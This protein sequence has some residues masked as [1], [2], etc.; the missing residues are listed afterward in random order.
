[1]DAQYIIS[2]AERIAVLESK[3]PSNLSLIISIISALIAATV[4]LLTCLRWRSDK[5]KNENEQ[6][7]FLIISS[8]TYNSSY[9]DYEFD[10]EV[11]PESSNSSFI[12]AKLNIRQIST[13]EFLPL[14]QSLIANVR[15]KGATYPQSQFNNINTFTLTNVGADLYH[16]E[17]NK[18][19]II[20]NDGQR[21]PV[22]PMQ[23][24]D[25]NQFLANS[26]TV[27]LMMSYIWDTKT[28]LIDMEILKK[29]DA[30]ADKLGIKE[31]EMLGVT[32][33]KDAAL[34]KTMTIH[35][36]TYPLHGPKRNQTITVSTENR[37]YSQI[38]KLMPTH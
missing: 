11:C 1:M 4:A 12:L 5:K 23:Q 24:K 25:V 32:L 30:I 13:G 9:E 3:I 28:A 38:P 10:K 26:G 19:E 8:N 17:I 37:M 36:T 34:F 31:G 16:F 35:F 27:D 33:P 6:A 14:K 2:L 7:P 21:I 20:M 18:I 15:E 29:C 22:E